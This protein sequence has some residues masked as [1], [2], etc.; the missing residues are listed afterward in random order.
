M[1]PA[2]TFTLP[3][4]HELK[5]VVPES[6]AERVGRCAS[7]YC[8]R[9]SYLDPGATRYT[10]TSLYLDT[11]ELHFFWDKKLLRWD[12][13]KLRIRTYGR[14]SE[15]PV[16]VEI[17][18]RYGDIVCKSR[19]VV[20]RDMWP[21]LVVSPPAFDRSLFPSSKLH[22]LEDFC[23]QCASMHL[24]PTILVRYEREPF[25]GRNDRQNRVTL[26]RSLRY[27]SAVDPVLASDDSGYLA[28]NFGAGLFTCEPRV[29]LEMKFNRGC[30]IWMMEL[31]E[32]FDLDR[33]SFSKYVR[34]VDEMQTDR[35][36]HAPTVYRS[37]L[38]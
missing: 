20:P 23:L 24:R 30:P 18:R 17:K 22:V 16:F 31:I 34:S 1:S 9:D 21:T 8:D 14:K 27:R 35:I 12:R 13:I 38:V 10:I 26:D 25:A 33:G 28:V 4:R 7:A 29:I 36:S 32:R 3:S 11:P 5:Y 6:I 2:A 37:A 19:T 15:G